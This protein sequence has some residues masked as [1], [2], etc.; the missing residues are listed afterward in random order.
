[1]AAVAA[2][3]GGER[4][5]W[6]PVWPISLISALK[7]KQRQERGARIREEKRER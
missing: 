1:M 5:D 3:R 2:D 6:P 7:S 4:R